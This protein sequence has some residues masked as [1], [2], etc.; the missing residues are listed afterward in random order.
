VPTVEPSPAPDPEVVLPTPHPVTDK[1]P[2]EEKP[3]EDKPK[4]QSADQVVAA[5]LTMAPPRVEATEQPVAVA[6]SPGSAAAAA[7]AKAAWE[8]ALVS[9]LNRFKRYPDAARARSSQGDVAVQFTIDRTGGVIASRVVRSSGSSALDEEAL[10]VL[11]RANPLPAPPGHVDGTTFDLTLPIQFRLLWSPDDTGDAAPYNVNLQKTHPQAAV[12]GWDVDIGYDSDVQPDG[13]WV[14]Q[15]EYGHTLCLPDEYFYSAVTSATVTYNKAD[16][17]TESVTI[18][19][20][21]N[22]IMKTHANRRYR[23]RFF[24]FVEIEAQE[25]LRRESGH[26]VT[27]EV[28]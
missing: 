18:E 7:R 5:P 3:Q 24:Y 4:Q 10:A 25:L 13:G 20:L 23:K 1:K 15:H 19:P 21:L 9:H 26:N 12:T 28:V 22:N 6:P 8:R 2:D 17:S 27:C 16:G 11:R 14:L